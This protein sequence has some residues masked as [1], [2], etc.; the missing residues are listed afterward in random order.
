VGT[1][2][3]LPIIAMTAHALKGD[4]QKCLDAGMDGYVSKPVK[5]GELYLA[6]ERAL[7]GKTPNADQVPS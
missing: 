3:R 6:M 2:D 4:E 5:A 7:A 1:G